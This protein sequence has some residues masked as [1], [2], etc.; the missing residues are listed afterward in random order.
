MLVV[1]IVTGMENIAIFLKILDIFDIYK[2]FSI[3]SFYSI[4]LGNV[5]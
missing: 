5:N 2:I 1:G 3:F 4:G